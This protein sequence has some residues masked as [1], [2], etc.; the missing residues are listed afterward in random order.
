V[1]EAGLRRLLHAI[2]TEGKEIEKRV[3][4]HRALFRENV[5]RLAKE[6]V[7]QKIETQISRLSA[8]DKGAE[9]SDGN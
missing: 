2:E 3:S 8:A 4:R 1:D 5:L 7:K 6:L 9:E